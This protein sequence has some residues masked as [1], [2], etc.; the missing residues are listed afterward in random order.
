M[1]NIDGID[2]L[3]LDYSEQE[4]ASLLD[5]ANRRIISNILK[6]YTGYFDLF[7]EMIQNALDATESRYRQ[8]RIGY[9]PKLWIEIDI[10]NRRVRVTDNG[11]GISADEFRFFLKPNMSFKKPRDF[12]GQ[13]GVGATFLAYGF[14]MLRVHTRQKGFE[15]AAIL[16]QGR[17]WAQDQ[18]GTVPRPTFEAE[19]FNCPELSNDSDGTCVEVVLGGAAGER[20]KRLDWQEARTADQWLDVLRIKTPLGGVY[21]KTGKFSPE[22]E[23]KVT[24]SNGTATSSTVNQPEYYYPHEMPSVKVSTV[25]DL[26][27][28]LTNIQ[29]DAEQ[30]FTKLN[31]EY[32]RLDCL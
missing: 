1:L 22:V 6:S 11:V 5:Q 19:A 16:R 7:S 9:T 29:G 32:K 10:E 4:S 13:K 24:D 8:E 28:A 2:P 25:K 3:A 27:S 17:Q 20:P 23:I 15:V 14:S 30:K 26:E 12:R 18:N 21:L 31:S